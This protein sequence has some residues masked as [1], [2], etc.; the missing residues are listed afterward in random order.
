MKC[1]LA[2]NSINL[3]ANGNIIPCCRFAMKAVYDIENIQT[4]DNLKNINNSSTFYSVQQDLANDKW[5]S[6]CIR[7]SRDESLNIPSRRQIYNNRITENNIRIIDIDVGNFCNLKCIMCNSEFSTQWHNDQKF[8]YANGFDKDYK[9]P[10]SFF[11]RNISNSDINKI[12][13]YIESKDTAVEIELKG[14]EPLALPNSKYLID[15]LTSVKNQVDIIITSNGT[16]FPTWFDDICKKS[17]VRLSLSIDG[18]DEIYDYVRGTSK[19]NYNLFNN[20]VHKFKKSPVKEIFFNFVVQNTNVH[21]LAECI[22]KYPDILVN[23]IFLQNPKWL[24][25]WNMPEDS[26]TSIMNILQDIPKDYKFYNKI[27]SVIS[28]MSTLCNSDEYKKFV[29]FTALLDKKRNKN[30]PKIAPHLF[31]KQA[32]EE[33]NDILH[34]TI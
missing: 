24:Q 6:G 10:K 12:V 30:L 7:C 25:V 28:N 5:P 14:G 13:E 8:L 9:S 11:S 15:R 1:K 2:E 27:Q 31:T 33:Y 18:L 32:L 4:I 19:Y 20:N 22:N 23:P 26:K 3:T 21:Q 29:K 16:F 17:N 34:G